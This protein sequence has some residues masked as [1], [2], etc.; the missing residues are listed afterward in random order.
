MQHNHYEW[1]QGT[2]T[3]GRALKTKGEEEE[4]EA[5]DEAEATYQK[6][7]FNKSEKLRTQ[8][9][10]QLPSW[11]SPPIS[12]YIS[13]C[14]KLVVSHVTWSTTAY[15]SSLLLDKTQS[16]CNPWQFQVGKKV[17]RV[18]GNHLSEFFPHPCHST[19]TPHSLSP[20]S[21]LTPWLLPM[22]GVFQA[23]LR[24]CHSHI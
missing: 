11:Q 8:L 19:L 1:L 21:T 12:I 14:S 15:D 4:D 18:A 22:S 20:H 13:L 24:I 7:N 6:I 10:R 16:S 5:E 23:S 9:D 2:T 17:E 3:N